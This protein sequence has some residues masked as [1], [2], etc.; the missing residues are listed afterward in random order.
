MLAPYKNSIMGRR[1]WKANRAAVMNVRM[2]PN[3]QT[4]NWQDCN[5]NDSTSSPFGP[6]FYI[7]WNSFQVFFFDFKIKKKIFTLWIS[8]Y[9]DVLH[10]SFQRY[11]EKQGFV[12]SRVGV[13]SLVINSTMS[14][15]GGVSSNPSFSIL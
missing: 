14:N 5:T 8:V 15:L 11:F 4:K 9:E 13:C 12:I 10:Y 7:S 2:A 1:K 6:W 3:G